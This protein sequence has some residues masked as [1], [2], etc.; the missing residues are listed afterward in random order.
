MPP[1]FALAA[2]KTPDDL[3]CAVALFR[4]YAASLEVDLSFQ[5]FEAELAAMPGRYA[6]PAG[7]LLLVRRPNGTPVGCVGLRPLPEPGVCE[8]KRLYVSPEGRGLGLGEALVRALIGEARRAGYRG[9]LALYGK[10]GFEP[11][12]S[13]YETPIAGTVSLRLLLTDTA[14][15]RRP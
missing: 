14:G 1:T 12:A 10:L 2:V 3:A 11:A 13:Y 8:M 9:A 7:T 15:R 4:A 5:G 6:P